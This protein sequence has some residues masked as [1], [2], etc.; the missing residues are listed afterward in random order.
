MKPCRSY[1]AD[2]YESMSYSA[3]SD[4]KAVKEAPSGVGM[5]TMRQK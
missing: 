4:K 1:A 2:G 3:K 5:L